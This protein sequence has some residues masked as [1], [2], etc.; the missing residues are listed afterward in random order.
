MKIG[1]VLP[2]VEG[3]PPQHTASY[4]E[5]RALAVGAEASG[6]DSVWLSDH[7][8]FARPGTTVIEIFP[9]DCVKSTYLW[10]AV[11]LGLDYR[12]VIGKPGDYRQAFHVKPKPF[13]AAL[14]DALRSRRAAAEPLPAFAEELAQSL[15]A[16]S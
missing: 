10:L 13:A 14:D 6:F 9:E 2:L 4:A 8:L 12:A 16:A 5:I 1:L 15:R 7:L 11:R 3:W